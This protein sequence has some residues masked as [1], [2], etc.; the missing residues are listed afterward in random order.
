MCRDAKAVKCEAEVV[1]NEEIAKDIF[2]MVLQTK[3]VAGKT[4]P[5]QFINLYSSNNALL[6]PRPISICEVDTEKETITIVYA[7]VGKGTKEFS[8]LSQ[9]NN[10]NILGPL[11]NG[12][13]IDE[14][15]KENIVVGG[16]VGTPPLL[17]LVKHLK[18][19]TKIFLGFR[20]ESYLVEEFKKYGEVYIAT[21]DGSF[22]EKGTVVD[23]MNKHIKNKGQIYSCGPKPMLKA[24]R[25]WSIKNNVKA[26]LSLEERMGCGFGACVGCVVKIK[27]NN[28]IGYV[29]KKV[30]KDGPIFLAT[31]V[32]FGE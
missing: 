32:I 22:G 18:G 26:Q 19:N 2:K 8:Q 14:A 12:F 29:H 20:S 13:T 25:D 3:E 10:I 11:G 15:E 28:E 16:G 5:G 9:G 23:L 6:L 17:E 31:E 4:K 21:D 27:E 7:V 30:C 1:I 24:V